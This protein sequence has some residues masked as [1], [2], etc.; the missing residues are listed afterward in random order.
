MGST[1]SPVPYYFVGGV[2]Q[3]VQRHQVPQGSFWFVQNFRP[4][5]GRLEQTPYLTADFTLSALNGNPITP[6]RLL[7]L[8][9]DV[10]GNLRY[11]ILDEKQAR[12]VDPSNTT[13]QVGL[14]CIVQTAIPNLDDNVHQQCLLWGFN[15]ADFAATNDTITVEIVDATHFKWRKNTGA[16]SASIL[17]EPE[18]LLTINGLRVGFQEAD[19][20]TAGHQWSWT[21][22]V[23]HPYTGAA[24]STFNFQP[25]LAMYNT[26]LY[27]GG[28]ERNIMRVRESF[29]TSVGYVR[30]YGKYVVVYANHLM[31]GQ[32]SEG[33]HSGALGVVDGYDRLVTPFTLAWSHLENPDQLFSTT[34]NEA[35][36][37]TIPAQAA[38]DL[39]HLGITGMELWNNYVFTFLA[40][41]IYVTSYVGL[42]TVM[43][44]DPL[45]TTVG[46]I[47]QNGV[48]KTT[49][50]LYFIGRSNMY[51]LNGATPEPFG[52]QIR[53]RFWSEIV[54]IDDPNFQRTFGYH[55]ADRMEVIWVYYTLQNG[56]YQQKC[57]VYS[58]Q[59]R[60]W[61]FRNLPS[62]QTDTACG[63][64]TAIAPRYHTRDMLVY[65]TSAGLIAKDTYSYTDVLF[66]DT[67]TTGGAA[68]YTTPYVETAWTAYG[69]PFNMKELG[70]QN[71]D[72]GNLG[73]IQ[74]LVL[75]VQYQTADTLGNGVPDYV[76]A[77]TPWRDGLANIWLTNKPIS[78]RWV[79]YKFTVINQQLLCRDAVLNHYTDYIYQAKDV[80]K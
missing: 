63:N 8:A 55:D 79:T 41:A 40:D 11:F 56:W 38:S 13:I 57:L 58:E 29:I 31:I 64:I 7:R 73:Q 32:Y 14:P 17:I 76:Y 69:D 43:K 37:Y 49:R 35:D 71:I 59:T 23:N 20:Y 27:I 75:A 45:I 48:V 36:R 4:V 51:Y 33:I 60:K 19:G 61:Y 62:A 65:G 22:T 42:P 9:R 70:A 26:D 47:F 3:S 46:S 68:D 80:A 16:W 15:V 25:S 12:F 50:G 74:S 1:Y 5:K 28:L 34:I 54:P 21:R 6:V 18:V 39:S 53:D 24:S 2:D 77:A 78:F 67:R 66:K 30:A 72:A 52:D 44:T 10:G